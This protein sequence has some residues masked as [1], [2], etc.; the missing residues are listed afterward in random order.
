MS[1]LADMGISPRTVE[2]LRDLGHEVTHLHEEGLDKLSDALIL[3]KARREGRVLFTSDLDFSELVAASGVQIPSVIS[4][5]LKD[6]RP[7]NVNRH[8][9][10]ILKH[11]VDALERGAI[12]S[13][14]EGRIR[15][16][17]LPIE[18]EAGE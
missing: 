4:F 1:F 16:R 17:L 8:L 7:D 11:H 18:K 9:L 6:M 3:K 5:R 2:F 15:L 12:I 14:T 10:S 13:I